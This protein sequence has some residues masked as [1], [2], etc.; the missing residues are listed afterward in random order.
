ML[1]SRGTDVPRETNAPLWVIFLA[2]LCIGFL[3]GFIGVGGGFLIVPAIVFALGCSM[4]VAV[5]TSLLVIAFNSF[6]GLA[7]R[8]VTASIDWAVVAAFV[9][10][11]LGANIVTSKLVHRLDQR[12]LKREF[13]VF[14]LIVGV[15][16]ASVQQDSFQYG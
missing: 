11:G 4:Q 2:G 7:T 6:F 10:G 5:A 16:T 12:R 13:A 1:R 8:F 15:F 9:V 3:T 14:I